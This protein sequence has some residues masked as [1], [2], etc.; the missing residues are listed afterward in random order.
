MKTPKPAV[1]KIT[2]ET[3]RESH[4][5]T[6]KQRLKEAVLIVLQ[7]H[8]ALTA[9]EIATILCASGAVAYPTRSAIQPR[10]TE[11]VQGGM[12]RV[13]GKTEDKTTQRKVAVYAHVV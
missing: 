6:D 13:V 11:L 5:K 2:A 1:S 3:R 4:H 7:Q 9:K 10:L 12:I 8:G